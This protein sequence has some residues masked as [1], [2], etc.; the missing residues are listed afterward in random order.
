[1]RLLPGILPTTNP[2]YSVIHCKM[3]CT[4]QYVTDFAVSVG[5]LLVILQDVPFFAVIA[6]FGRA[7][8]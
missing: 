4:V 1:M 6:S 5:M 7:V 8:L 3:C 2:R